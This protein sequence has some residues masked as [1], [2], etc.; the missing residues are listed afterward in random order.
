[1]DPNVQFQGY[2]P[3]I[4]YYNISLIKGTRKYHTY[5]PFGSDNLIVL[6]IKSWALSMILDILVNVISLMNLSCSFPMEHYV[7]VT[8]LSLQRL[9]G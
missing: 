2:F 4:V 1:M 9:L 8:V 6:R 7:T 5:F 3:I